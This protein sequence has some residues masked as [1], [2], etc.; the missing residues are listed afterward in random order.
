[1]MWH[2]VQISFYITAAESIS[3]IAIG[4]FVQINGFL[5]VGP[6]PILSA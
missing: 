4:S 5:S 6:R 2:K 1:M 3:Y